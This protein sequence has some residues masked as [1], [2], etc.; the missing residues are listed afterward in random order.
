MWCVTPRLRAQKLLHHATGDAELLTV[1]GA[2]GLLDSLRSPQ[3]ALLILLKTNEVAVKV[4][5]LPH[6][7][8]NTPAGGCW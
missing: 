2:Q 4:D 3:Q 7:E 5:S 1:T 8:R 6:V